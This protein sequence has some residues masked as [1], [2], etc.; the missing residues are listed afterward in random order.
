MASQTGL[1][2]ANSKPSWTRVPRAG[3]EPA[4]LWLKTRCPRPLDER[5]YIIVKTILCIKTSPSAATLLRVK[6]RT[7]GDERG[8]KMILTKK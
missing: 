7:G 2:L 1:L 6:L 5:G 4:I 8:S 3:F